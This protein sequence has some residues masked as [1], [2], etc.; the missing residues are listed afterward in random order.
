MKVD[1]TTIEYKKAFI[2]EI[3]ESNKKIELKM[4]S[5]TDSKEWSHWNMTMGFNLD[6]IKCFKEDIKEMEKRDD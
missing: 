1:T 5:I 6:S 4:K 2:K 3:E